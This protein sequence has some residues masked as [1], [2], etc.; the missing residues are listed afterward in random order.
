MNW[1]AKILKHNDDGISMDVE[2]RRDGY[3]PAI[4]GVML[5]P[6]GADLAQHLAAYAP[7]TSWQWQ[8]EL[9]IER[10]LPAIG[11]EVSAP[12]APQ[13]QVVETIEPPTIR[14]EPLQ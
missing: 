13:P 4:V 14:L 5:P 1:T 11:T 6:A 7:T 10:M 9:K 3:E 2:Y 8:D 12:P